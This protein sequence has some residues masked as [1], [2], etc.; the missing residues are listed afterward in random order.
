MEPTLDQLIIATGKA[1][2]DE[3]ITT[4]TLMKCIER[5]KAPTHYIDDNGE[6]FAVEHIEE[7]MERIF[8]LTGGEVAEADF[9]AIIE[10][11]PVTFRAQLNDLE[12]VEVSQL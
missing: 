1:M 9:D 3:P 7:E 10:I 6:K 8:E 5:L 2:K 4:A 12:D 11:D